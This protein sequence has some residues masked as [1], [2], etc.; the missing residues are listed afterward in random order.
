MLSAKGYTDTTADWLK[1]IVE[2][3]GDTVL[4]DSGVVSGFA[5]DNPPADL[6]ETTQIVQDV[7]AGAP[8]SVLWF[9]ALF[10][11]KGTTVSQTNGGGLGNG[12]LSGAEF[13]ELV[14][15]ANDQG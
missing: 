1:C 15:A 13:M 6:P 12:S 14:Q 7:I 11:S 9:E 8:S 10:T 3:Y 4:A 2:N 5:L